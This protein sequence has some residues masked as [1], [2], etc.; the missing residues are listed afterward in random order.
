MGQYKVG[1]NQSAQAKNLRKNSWKRSHSCFN[2]LFCIKNSEKFLF[3]RPLYSSFEKKK[4]QIFF[5]FCWRTY[6]IFLVPLLHPPSVEHFGKI[7]RGQFII[8]TKCFWICS[9]IPKWLIICQWG[10]FSLLFPVRKKIRGLGKKL[11]RSI[12]ALFKVKFLINL[13]SSRSSDS[14]GGGTGS[15]EF[16]GG[17]NVTV[18]N[19]NREGTK[20]KIS[21]RILKNCFGSEKIKVLGP[22]GQRRVGPIAW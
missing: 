18:G 4:I 12:Q 16:G 7:V 8:F 10:K 17:V 6:R 5:F 22:T 3:K 9:R 15:D 14:D 11:I 1:Q 20:N 13:T 19:R 21:I 2:K